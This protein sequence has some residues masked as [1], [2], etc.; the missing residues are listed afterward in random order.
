MKA[1]DVQ[2]EKIW[3]HIG[4]GFMPGYKTTGTT[5]ATEID[6]VAISLSWTLGLHAS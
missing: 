1:A 5:A 6:L 4:Y 2:P 3:L